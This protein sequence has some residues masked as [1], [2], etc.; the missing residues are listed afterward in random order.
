[1]DWTRAVNLYCER[2]DAGFWSEP[3]NALSNAGFLVAA[4]LCWRMLQGRRDPGARLLVL[5]LAAIGIGSFL[6]HT[7]AE[8][9]A[10]LADILPILLFI[11]IYVHLATT[12]FFG[13]PAWAG[14][15]AVVAF[16]PFSALVSALAA[17]LIGPLDG[18]AG[19]LP[20]LLL[21]ALY[22]LVL[23]GRAP[24]TAGRL[25]VGAGLFAIS[26]GF[27]TLDS[28]ICPVF[29]LGTHFLWHLLNAVMLG[30]MVRTLV[31]HA[32]ASG[33]ASGA[34]LARGGGAG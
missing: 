18:S 29:P 9:W 20:V 16:L 31:L 12:R 24:A 25:A 23:R 28:D 26:L 22:A 14:L 32:S 21:I 19:Y 1:M 5:V 3:V 10:G 6:F 2:T 34:G 27:R 15:A 8:A 11:L 30:W 13:L 17:R 33:A 4:A 7:V